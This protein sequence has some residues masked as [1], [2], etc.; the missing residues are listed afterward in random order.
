MAEQTQSDVDDL[1]GLQEVPLDATQDPTD[2]ASKAP[3]AKPIQELK[4][5]DT[6]PPQ[7]RQIN[8]A[9]PTRTRQA[10]PKSVKRHPNSI[11]EPNCPNV[12]GLQAPK[13]PTRL[14]GPRRPTHQP[15]PPKPHVP[16]AHPRLGKCSCS[17]VRPSW[18]PPTPSNKEKVRSL[19][20]N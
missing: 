11:R 12:T 20:G 8:A 14:G 3:Y 2:P 9:S 7:G 10:A 1:D 13:R 5:P 16:P 17:H 19:M 15:P 18:T 4:E 6:P